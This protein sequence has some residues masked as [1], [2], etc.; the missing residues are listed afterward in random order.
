M[1]PLRWSPL[2]QHLIDRELQAQADMVERGK[3]LR[4]YVERRDAVTLDGNTLERV[5]E[6]R[7]D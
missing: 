4:A 6:E 3:R 1:S 7:A 5:R 2:P